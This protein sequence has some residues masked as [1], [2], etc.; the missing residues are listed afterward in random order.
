ML[1]SLMLCGQI[2]AAKPTLGERVTKYTVKATVMRMEGN[3]IGSRIRCI[4]QI[5]SDWLYG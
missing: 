1:I 2:L 3:I 5:T 4:G